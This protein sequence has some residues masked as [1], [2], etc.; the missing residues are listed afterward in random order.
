MRAA[1][2]QRKNSAAGIVLTAA[3]V[4]PE[5]VRKSVPVSLFLVSTFSKKPFLNICIYTPIHIN[6][7]VDIFLIGFPIL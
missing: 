3:V 1:A 2:T 6:I 7:A 4:F 5:L